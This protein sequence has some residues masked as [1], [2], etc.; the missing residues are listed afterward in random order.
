MCTRNEQMFDRI[1]F[2]RT[3]S[4]NTFTPATLG[5]EVVDRSPLDVTSMRDRDHHRLFF[6]HIFQIDFP[7]FLTCN[8]GISI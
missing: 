6:D 2:L 4:D 8:L 3:G 1:F 7:D 5:S